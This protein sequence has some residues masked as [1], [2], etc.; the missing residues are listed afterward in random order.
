MAKSDRSWRVTGV[1]R[2]EPTGGAHGVENPA[3]LLGDL[4]L[5]LALLRRV[6]TLM[7]ESW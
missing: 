4:G 6:L 3:L 7:P 2:R 1:R 5:G